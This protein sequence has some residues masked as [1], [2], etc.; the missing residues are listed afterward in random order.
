MKRAV[1]LTHAEFEG[2]AAIAD[3]VTQEGYALDVRSLHRGER[4]PEDLGRDDLLIVMGGSMGVADVD[5]PQFPYLRAEVELLKRRVVEEAPVLGV[6]LGAQ[7]LAH[8]AGAS[9]SP[10]RTEDGLPVYEVGWAPIR[11]FPADNDDVL[12]GMPSEAS[13]LHWHGDAFQVP[14][15]ARL[16]A[17]SA[18]CR[19]Q[20]FRLGRRQFGL[21]F[22]CELG[23]GDIENFLRGD[24]DYVR[25]ANGPDGIEALRRDTHRYFASFRKVGDRLLQN[26][27]R[28]MI[29]N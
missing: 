20:G 9:V 24:A 6:C 1:V 13:V 14:P 16:L 19:N 28:A 29:A 2:P 4:A 22:H 18:V 27:V 15:G 5:L 17:S 8:A 21:Q 25:Q 26:I 12:V 3:L 7:L 23:V 11:F 10:M